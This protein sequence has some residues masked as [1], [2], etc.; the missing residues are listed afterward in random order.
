MCSDLIL[1]SLGELTREQCDLASSQD[2][3]VVNVTKHVLVLRDFLRDL[4]REH[5]TIGQVSTEWRTRSPS[6]AALR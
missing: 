4:G 1:R 5:M 6:S 2:V 3:E